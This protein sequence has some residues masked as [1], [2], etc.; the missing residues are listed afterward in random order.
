MRHLA[1]TSSA[2]ATLHARTS[3]ERRSTSIDPRY[4]ARAGRLV[5]CPVP[6]ALLGIFAFAVS[7]LSPV[8][9][10][11]VIDA[12]LRMRFSFDSAPANDVIVDSSPSATHPG[13]NF[14]AVWSSSELGRTGVMDFKAP[15]PNRITVPASLALNSSTGTICFWLKTP[16]NLVRGDFAAILFDR[17]TSDGDVITLMDTGTIFVQARAGGANVNSFAAS[18]GINDNNWHHVAYVYDQSATG[19]ISIYVDGVLDTSQPNSQA[20]SWP[21]SRA[22]EL[23]SSDDTFWRVFVGLMDD[24]QIHNRMLS[25]GEIAAT[26]AGNPVLDNSLVERLD[27]GAAAVNNVVV[28]TSASSNS[29]TNQGATWVSADTGHSGLMRFDL[30]FTQ[31]TVAADP[32]FNSPTGTI[33]F[34]MKS[35][36]NIGPGAFASILFDRRAGGYG[37]VITMK[38]DGTIFVQAQSSGQNVNSFATQGSVNDGLWHH[39]AYIYDQ[40]DTGYIQIYIDGA[41]SGFQTNSAAWSWAPD[42]PIELALSHDAYWFGF[43]GALDEVRFY[44]RPL[45][46]AEVAIIA[47]PS[48]HFDIKPASQTAFIGDDVV[49]TSAANMT[50]TYQWRFSGT[51]LPGSTST[52]LALTNVQA[53][54]AGAYTMVAS[55]TNFG[56]ITSAPAILT[57]SARPSLAAS[58][59]ARYEFG[60]APVNGVIVDNV[61]GSAHPGTN[62]LATWAA[63]VA[64]RSGVMQFSPA[65]PGSQIAVPPHPDFNSTKGTIAFWMKSPGNDLTFGSFASIIFDRRTDSGN[66]ITLV[67]DGTLFVQAF[68]HNFHVN[69]FAT[70]TTVNDD[71]WHHVAHVYDQGVNGFIRIYVDGQLDASNPNTG[72]WAWDPAEE[73]ELGESYDTFW[74]RYNGSLDD[75]QFYNR[76]LSAAEVVQS[77]TLGPWISFTRAGNQLTLSWPETGFVLQQNSDLTNPA[78]WSNIAGGSTSPVTVTISASGNKYYRLL[79]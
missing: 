40:S 36:G 59:V 28:D 29:A 46:A 2:A 45:S 30:A 11:D 76:V 27:F 35:S 16:G 12:S 68:S 32:D 25:A 53:A 14:G 67:D 22:I 50:A 43:E 13:T 42:Q 72:P 44:N 63:S 7:S 23:G 74:R 3:R 51:N 57:L 71:L 10:A 24:F 33:A 54:N 5:G 17:R 34:W 38:D 79:K 70:T 60:A 19:S 39:V 41:S 65:D 31:I 62:R 55:N 1:A 75:V 47:P 66:V 58:L 49:F 77:M 9:A 37:D 56:S 4:R 21:A 26:F 69:Q 6:A 20:W 73:I 78:G 18:T 48:F 8:F 15:I 61:P 52:S 64:G